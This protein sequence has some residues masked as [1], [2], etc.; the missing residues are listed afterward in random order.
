MEKFKEI[1]EISKEEAMQM[2]LHQKFCTFPNFQKL[3][4]EDQDARKTQK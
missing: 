4:K 3:M 1:K 2:F